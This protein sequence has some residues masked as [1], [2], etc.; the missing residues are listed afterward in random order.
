MSTPPP[1]GGR[2]R[3][4]MSG[5]GASDPEAAG[6]RRWQLTWPRPQVLTVSQQAFQPGLLLAAGLPCASGGRG[7]GR[8][9][10]EAAAGGP[11]AR[12]RCVAATV[13]PRRARG[14][15]AAGGPARPGPGPRAG[16]CYE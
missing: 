16:F 3:A 6:A 5:T 8:G 12:A 13:P 11:G 14:H 1:C 2:T 4:A 10:P 15:G 7:A 9:R